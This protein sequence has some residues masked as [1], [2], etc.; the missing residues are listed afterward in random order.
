MEQTKLSVCPSLRFCTP[1]NGKLPFSAKTL[2][3]GFI[4]AESAVIGLLSGCIGWDMSM[5][6][7]L[8][9]GDVSLTH[10]NFSD[11]IVT[12]VKVMNCWLTPRLVSCDI[13]KYGISM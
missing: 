1:V 10:M 4:S 7:T 12:C 8:L 13:P 6:T 5:M 3:F 9:A 11:S 2:L